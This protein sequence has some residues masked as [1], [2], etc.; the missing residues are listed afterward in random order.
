MKSMRSPR[1]GAC[2]GVG[3]GDKAGLLVEMQAIDLRVP[4]QAD[5][6]DDVSQHTQCF[7]KV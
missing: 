6:V 3:M 1:G 2:A 7:A 4:F 5:S